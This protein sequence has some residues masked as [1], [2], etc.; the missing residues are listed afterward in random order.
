MNYMYKVLNDDEI[1][2]NAGVAIEFN[3]P[4][5]SKRVDFI[6][7][8]YGADSDSEMVIVELKQWETLNEVAGTDALVDTFTGGV[9]R[10]VVHPSYQAWS[11]AQ[12]IRDYNASVQDRRVKLSPCACLHNYIRHENDPID[13]EQYEEYIE[14]APAHTKGQLP[15]EYGLADKDL[16]ERFEF[17]NIS[18]DEVDQAIA[19]EQICFPPNEAC[20]PK[21]MKE[22]VAAA[23][24]LFLVAVDKATGKIA[25]FLNGLSTKEYQFR[26]EFFTDISL[27]D[28]E[29]KHIMLL[30]LDVLPEY[31][32][33]GLAREIVY[34]YCRRENE[35]GRDMLHLIMMISNV[36][37]KV[38]ILQKGG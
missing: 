2:P 33:Q 20:S 8:G 28:P 24:E 38:N 16:M 34:Q 18:Q 13:A 29:G 35:K 25:G 37:E 22:R 26:D 30:G 5:T 3:I 36:N 1:P 11:Y 6:I 10:R 32:K 27:Y 31:R 23:P 7:S 4:Q 9:N 19:I 21:A 14:E 15:E 12:L 17:R